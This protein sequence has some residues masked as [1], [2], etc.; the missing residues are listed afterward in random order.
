M[1]TV[2]ARECQGAFSV[3][4]FTMEKMS[5]SPLWFLGIFSE[6]TAPSTSH[7]F[8]LTTQLSTL[9]YCPKLGPP[10]HQANEGTEH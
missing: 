6:E 7:S 9:L 8:F 4:K 1:V 3:S 10:T 5:Q 2:Q